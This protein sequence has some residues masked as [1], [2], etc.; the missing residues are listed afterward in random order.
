MNSSNTLPKGRFLVRVLTLA[1]P[2]AAA[3]VFIADVESGL[4]TVPRN[5]VPLA[6]TLLLGV[7]AL[8]RN[9]AG[10]WSPEPRW[11]LVMLGFAIPAVGLSL[12]LHVLWQFD[13][14]GLRS[15]AT[16]TRLLFAYLPLYTCVAGCIG[17]ALGWII[18]RGLV[19]ASA[20]SV[21]AKSEQ[22]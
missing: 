6:I 20:D 7:N 16:Q 14:D 5:L 4:D 10:W 2:L 18:G 8:V 19:R 17:A 3:G 21:V 9:G 13:I 1:L 22:R 12:Y 15:G 11:S